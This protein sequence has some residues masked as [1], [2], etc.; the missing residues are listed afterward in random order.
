MSTN[1]GIARSLNHNFLS[2]QL[3]LTKQRKMTQ[4]YQN[5]LLFYITDLGAEHNIPTINH[6][7]T[8]H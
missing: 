7:P 2:S 5:Q 3:H 6:I 1:S 4:N 8:L